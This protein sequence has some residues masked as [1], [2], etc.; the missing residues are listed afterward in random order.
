M[1]ENLEAFANA[2]LDILAGSDDWGADTL[3][4]IA[5]TARRLELGTS[6]PDGYFARVDPAAPANGFL[7]CEECGG[8]DVQ[9]GCNAWF[10]WRWELI[11]I[12]D[13]APISYACQDCNSIWEPIELS[14]DELTVI[15]S[16]LAAAITGRL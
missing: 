15:S 9:R 6:D 10:D 12:G 5:E 7:I 11:C 1:T 4:D 8:V 2:V 16:N 3:D 13:G 14:G